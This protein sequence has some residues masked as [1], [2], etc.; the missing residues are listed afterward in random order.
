MIDVSE[1]RASR[2]T[3]VG[4]VIALALLFP[5]VGSRQ[6]SFN[7]HQSSYEASSYR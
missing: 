1:M 5:K 4:M 2:S 3:L 7:P 6:T